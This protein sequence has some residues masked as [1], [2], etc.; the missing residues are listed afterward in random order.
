MISRVDETSVPDTFSR[1]N[2]TDRRTSTPA[3]ASF[4]S[5]ESLQLCKVRLV[6]SSWGNGKVLL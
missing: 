6:D 1:K 2:D 4:P 5:E 3:L